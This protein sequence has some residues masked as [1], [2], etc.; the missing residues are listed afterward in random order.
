MDEPITCLDVEIKPSTVNS[1]HQLQEQWFEGIL[2]ESELLK[3][4]DTLA[5][6]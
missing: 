3:A 2:S 6:D 4:V 1:L 5:I